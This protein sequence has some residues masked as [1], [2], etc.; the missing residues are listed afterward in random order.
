MNLYTKVE[1]IFNNITPNP[2][3]KL[4]SVVVTAP[5]CCAAFQ[6]WVEEFCVYPWVGS[7]RQILF[8]SDADPIWISKEFQSAHVGYTLT[9]LHPAS[10]FSDIPELW[11]YAYYYHKANGYVYSDSVDKQAEVYL[12]WLSQKEDE[13]C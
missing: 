5:F 11:L 3:R 9:V 10:F 13:L 7:G 2:N 6:D 1:D 8:V 12:E 4:Y